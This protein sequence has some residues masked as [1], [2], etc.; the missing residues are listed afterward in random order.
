MTES[1]ST[2]AAAS[3]IESQ[4]KSTVVAANDINLTG[5][6][7]KSDTGELAVLAG[8]NVNLNAARNTDFT[9]SA[10]SKS[11]GF[12]LS[13]TSKMASDSAT[14]TS[15]T[16]ST[17][18]GNTTLVQ[19]GNDVLLS[20]SN[21]VSTQET[22]VQARNDVRIESAAETFDAQHRQSTKKSGLMGTGGIG[23]TLGSAKNTYQQDTQSQTQKG[24]TVGSVLGDVNVTAGKDLDV[25]ASD[26]VAGKDIRLIGQNVSIRD[27]ANDASTRSLQESKKAGLTLALSGVVGEAVNTT[28]QT[29]KDAKGEDDTR[30]SA[31]QGVK[32][33]LS[34]YQAWQGA[35]ALEAGAQAGSFFGIALS[36][37][38]QKSSSN[39]LE[40]QSVSQGSSLTAGNN[41]S[42]IATG[43]GQSEAADGDISVQGSK[44]QAGNDLLL[45]AAR[46]ID[47]R[48]G[49]NTQKLEGSNKSSG[50]AVG[51]SFGFGSSGA[52]LS[53]F[54]NG[55][56]GSGREKGNGTVWTETSVNA[57]NQLT[58]NSGRDTTLDG[59]QATAQKIVAD[60]K[61]NLT[62]SSQ[63]DTDRYDSKQSDV[64]GGASFTI[65][66][67]T[68][69][70]SVS[71]SQ[72]K[73]KSDFDSVKEQTGL[74]AGKDGYQIDVGGHTQLNGSVIGSTA[75]A[76]KNRLST[77]TL[78]WTNIGNKAEFS[79]QSQSITA[80]TGGGVG[81]MFTGN[82]G[83]V[84]L[85]GSN[86]GGDDK[87]TTYSAISNGE[88][89]VRDQARQQQDVATLS[90]DVEHANNALSPIFDKEKEQKRLR[91]TQLIAEIA[92]QSMDIIRTQ[93]SI[94]AAKAGQ[95][96]LKD[97]HMPGEDPNASYEDRQAYVEALQGT[98]GYKKAMDNYG[99][100]SSLQRAAQALTAAVQGLAGGDLTQAVVGASAPYL[101]G[102]IK[103]NTGDDL[104]ARL[105]AHAMLGAVLA[106]SQQNSAVAGAAGAS[107]GELIA[108]QLYPDTP[109]DQLSET[110]K[111]NISALSTLAGGI[112]GGIVGGDSANAVAGA[113]AAKNAVENNQL[114]GAE[115]TTLIQKQK[116]F[117]DSCKGVSSA[118]CQ[119]LSKDIDELMKKAGSLLPETL[120]V[121]DDFLK[122]PATTVEPGQ[123]VNCATSGNGVCV[124]SSKMIQTDL[125]QE[126]VLEP[127]SYE[128]S[129][130]YKAKTATELA[131]AKTQ[132]DQTFQ[133]LYAAGCGGMGPAGI[134]CQG[135]MA[136]G[137]KNPATGLEATAAERVMFGAQ[138]VLNGMGVVGVMSA[139]SGVAVKPSTSGLVS[140]ETK[141]VGTGA[142]AATDE[143]FAVPL[144]NGSGAKGTATTGGQAASTL[145][146]KLGESVLSH[147][148]QIGVRNSKAGTISGAHNSD[149]FLESVE[150][151]GAKISNKI[152]DARFPGL[153][154]YRYQ[155][156]RTNTKGELIGGYKPTS[157]KTTYDPKVIP[158]SK[159]ADM[160]SRAAVQADALF[161]TSP[162]LREAS[163]KVDG[164]YFQVT[165]NSKTGE[166]TNSFITMPPR[167]N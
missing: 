146:Q 1:D 62:L 43:S 109:L 116:Q 30:L 50:G 148:T 12:G 41:L 159:V 60:V 137:G 10:K 59:V 49:I 68:G 162:A 164:Y 34:G 145:P 46:D 91:Q 114:R 42:V 74:F 165:R 140:G 71:V 57:G 21:I 72:S 28:I 39:Q 35:Q 90:R 81:T 32:A 163:I 139:G 100:G 88:V 63:Q 122:S 19:A 5:S 166:I 133:N 54:A 26:I 107:I 93:G 126:R 80:G 56:S 83:S 127:A 112:A 22:N 16:G 67:M 73:I 97:K 24:S 29:A 99:T 110:E 9:Q 69:S 153:V 11:G 119:S 105:M 108:T 82:M 134:A 156:P 51:L 48:S 129:E 86:N 37:G 94:E 6:T 144:V 123:L 44:L 55:N 157:T 2:Q 23:V 31:L 132:L 141:V 158:D 27:A 85:V 115:A 33:G 143:S 58:M 103:D 77:G 79:S 117:A 138:A 104:T 15:L 161:K 125:G 36:L 118:Q 78:G 98:T 155:L 124:V 70:G 121:E 61:R 101:A 142:A 14:T 52:G 102:V 87:S 89:N 120:A 45:S 25:T 84:L 17:L 96:E 13:T 7:V 128:Q 40:E 47:L 75:S 149:A 38:S 92:N 150:I 160:S 3:V 64:S 154:E 53:I 18:S 135:Y 111:Q 167:T 130:I 4:G 8:N 106:K 152:T 65:G 20:A 76:D 95:A 136:L 147:N 151:T 131:T 66:T 113:G